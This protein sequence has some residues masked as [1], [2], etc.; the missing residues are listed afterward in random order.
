MAYSPESLQE[1]L[2][3][4]YKIE[5]EAGHGG[6]AIVFRAIDLKHRRPVAIK[7][8]RPEIAAILGPER[9]L[10]EIEIAA[11]LQHPHILP[12]HDSG[13]ANG[14][15]YY[16]MPFVEGESVRDRLNREHQLPLDEALQI[17]REVANALD[18]AHNHGVIHRDIKPENILWTGEHAIV[19]DFG[20]ARA[21]SMASGQNLTRTGILLGTPTYMSPEQATGAPQIDGRTDLYSLGCVLYEMLA[22]EP[23]FAGPTAE[24]LVYQHLHT[25]ARPVTVFRTA[26]PPNMAMAIARALAKTPADRFSTSAQFV[27]ALLAPTAPPGAPSAPAASGQRRRGLSRLSRRAVVEMMALA[28]VVAA[29]AISVRGGWL[30]F[31]LGAGRIRSIAVLPLQ[32]L[33]HDPDQEYFA[34]GMTEELITSL[35]SLQG[36]R[37]T[38]RTSVM[39][40]KGTDKAVPQIGRELKV[41]AIIEGSVQR[42]GQQVRITAQLIHAAR[43]QHLW[44]QSYE[45][46]LE[47]VLEIQSEVAQAITREVRVKLTPRE[48]IKLASAEAVDPAAHEAYLKGRYYTNEPNASAIQKGIEFF[49]QAI[50]R[51][52]S[53]ALAYSGLADTYILLAQEGLQDPNAAYAQ[54]RELAAKGIALD[55]KLAEAH[56]SMA[57][58]NLFRWEWAD[59]ERE[60]KRA[61]ELKPSYAP[62]H[63]R[64]ANYLL[65]VGRLDEA[66]VE[67]RRARE[68]DPLDL[69]INWN[70]GVCLYYGRR[71]GE[72]ADQFRQIV[73]TNPD[74]T[75][76]R[77]AHLWLGLSYEQLGKF[78]EAIIE[79]EKVGGREVLA[80]LA[81]AQAMAG[82][83]RQAR[84]ILQ[85]FQTFAASS[86]G[87]VPALE[88]AV[89]Y[90]GLGEKDK[91]LE[92]LHKA[93]ETRSGLLLYL[94]AEPVFA[95]LHAEPRF[96]ELV[97]RIGLPVEDLGSQSRRGKA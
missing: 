50:S 95:A 24:N 5:H 70:L 25:E 61:I 16:V 96:R 21:I 87:Y 3:G 68:L 15:L 64:Y 45:R 48:E 33:S 60:F 80:P 56:A 10:R 81:H 32:N 8:L 41:D 40:Y 67:A 28:L 59:A 97:R 77:A 19:T 39:R 62:A 52:P 20:I 2:A 22:G 51:D 43:D 65:A 23:P 72:S 78:E 84:D 29:V 63:S 17:T 7:V 75:I 42:S 85:Q 27:A 74:T 57:T 14:F 11:R 55:P 53:F 6:M 86:R 89:I 1:S 37:V 91:A 18:H 82:R 83:E 49:N 73:E 12:L 9:F 93:Y 35:A 88:I 69:R 30:P 71:Y 66:V 36:I 47:N 31:G 13:Q 94:Q 90:S 34:D 4:R 38:S 46:S 54:A 26:V 76:R 92:W 79:F 58:A 44:A